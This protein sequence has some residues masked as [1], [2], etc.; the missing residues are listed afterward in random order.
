MFTER[1]TSI[2][3]MRPVERLVTEP[4]GAVH[5]GIATIARGCDQ[6]AVTIAGDVHTLEHAES[7]HSQIDGIVE[8]LTVL[9]AQVLQRANLVGGRV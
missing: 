5:V 6:L 7:L 1:V 8:R 2:E 4:V 9:Q 3:H